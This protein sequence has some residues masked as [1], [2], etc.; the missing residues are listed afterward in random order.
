M[1]TGQVR[2]DNVPLADMTANML[3]VL[4]QAVLVHVLFLEK[5]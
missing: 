5:L 3:N 2:F 1:H 4:E